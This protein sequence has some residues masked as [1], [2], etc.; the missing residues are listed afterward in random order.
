M[1]IPATVEEFITAIFGEAAA[2][3]EEA[4]TAGAAI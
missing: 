2:D 3:A 4:G 1:A